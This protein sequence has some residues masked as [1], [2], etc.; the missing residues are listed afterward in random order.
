V[1]IG[2]VKWFD[3]AKGYGFIEPDSDSDD[4]FVHRSAVESAGMAG[5]IEGDRVRFER[6]EAGGRIAAAN[7]RPVD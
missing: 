6:V 7:L 1:A 5:L 2:T 4:V 3:P